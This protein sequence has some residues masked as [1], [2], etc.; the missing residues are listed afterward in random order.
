M[1]G[2]RGGN[3]SN[4]DVQWPGLRHHGPLQSESRRVVPSIPRVIKQPACPTHARLQYWIAG[5]KANAGSFFFFW[6]AGFVLGMFFMS[7]GAGACRVR[8]A[9]G[10]VTQHSGR[11]AVTTASASLDNSSTHSPVLILPCSFLR[12]DALAASGPDRQRIDNQ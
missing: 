3:G 1:R 7:V 12:A 2:V 4:V 9:P 8:A 10:V 11:N 5:L 6:F